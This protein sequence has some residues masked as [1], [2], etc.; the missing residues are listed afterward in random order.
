MI[1]KGFGDT[2][3]TESVPENFTECLK[4]CIFIHLLLMAYYTKHSRYTNQ[5]KNIL[6][7]RNLQYGVENRKLKQEITVQ[8]G[9][10]NDGEQHSILQTILGKATNLVTEDPERL[11]KKSDIYASHH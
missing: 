1:N 3:T 2:Q 7:S 6:P 8:D 10:K 11:H 4:K 9:N 5:K